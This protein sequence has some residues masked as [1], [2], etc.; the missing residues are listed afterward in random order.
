MTLIILTIFL[1]FFHQSH[2]K[3][4]LIAQFTPD[5]ATIINLNVS[6]C[7]IIIKEKD[8]QNGYSNF[9]SINRP[10][11]LISSDSFISSSF[12]E[13]NTITVTVNNPYDPAFCTVLFYMPSTETIGSFN[14]NCSSCNLFQETKMFNVQN[15]ITITGN[16]IEANLA[17]LVTE[18]FNFIANEGYLQVD[19]ITV[20]GKQ[21]SIEFSLKGDIIIQSD[22]SMQIGFNSPSQSFCFGG[23]YINVQTNN[24]AVSGQGIN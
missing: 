17:Y 18:E 2:P 20:T 5:A 6:S 24:C 14:L 9:I 12:L 8:N 22:A 15:F 10:H 21:N 19:M 4:N 7:N 11:P 3:S 23:P 16:D 1:I 13:G